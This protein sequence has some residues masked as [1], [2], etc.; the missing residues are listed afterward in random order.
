VSRQSSDDLIVTM[1]QPDAI[2]PE[3][4]TAR[5]RQLGSEHRPQNSLAIAA[6]VG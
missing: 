4:N 1:L 2:V 6:M 3:D 5:E